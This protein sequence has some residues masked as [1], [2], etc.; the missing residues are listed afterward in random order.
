MMMIY[1]YITRTSQGRIIVA[2]R[3]LWGLNIL[4]QLSIFADTQ[5]LL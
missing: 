5:R 3:A 2:A 4:P 1:R